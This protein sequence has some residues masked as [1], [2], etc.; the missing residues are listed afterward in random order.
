MHNDPT[1]HCVGL[2]IGAL[3]G[4]IAGAIVN[5][6]VQVIHNYQSG[7]T[8]HDSL[9]QIDKKSIAVAAI[10][11]AVA[12]F[13]MGLAAGAAGVFATTSALGHGLAFT[14]EYVVGG[15]LANAAAG[16]AEALASAKLDEN[17]K[18]II[19]QSREEFYSKARDAGYKNIEKMEADAGMGAVTGLLLG[20][21]KNVIGADPR[22]AKYTQPEPGPFIRPL[23][24]GMDWMNQYVSQEQ[25]FR[26]NR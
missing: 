4:A 20:T 19:H 12:G 10:G 13:T 21:G 24:A 26:K 16:Q 11:G 7:K 15:A 23:T 5:Y 8:F 3:C 2:L 1:G 25:K 17:G 18:I 9:T 6:T 14:T 22:T